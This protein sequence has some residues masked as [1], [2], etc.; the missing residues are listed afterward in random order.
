MATDKN[1][2]EYDG[3]PF[4]ALVITFLIGGLIGAFIVPIITGNV[5]VTCPEYTCQLT[6]KNAEYEFLGPNECNG[7]AWL[8]NAECKVRLRNKESQ[9]AEF[10]VNARCHT[11]TDSEEVSATKY[12]APGETKEFTLTYTV[13]ILQDWACV[14]GPI[15]SNTVQGCNL[16]EK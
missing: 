6:T 12:L 16:V 8:G 10:K 13:K 2:I 4:I 5:P 14:I 7:K 3:F 15:E 9:G 11:V 1:H